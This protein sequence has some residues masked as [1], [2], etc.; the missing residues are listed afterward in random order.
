MVCRRFIMLSIVPCLSDAPVTAMPS[1][2][3]VGSI[4]LHTQ[5]LELYS[6]V[7]AR[8]VQITAR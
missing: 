8:E 1:I 3:R 6:R 5:L 7:T 4:R 2:G